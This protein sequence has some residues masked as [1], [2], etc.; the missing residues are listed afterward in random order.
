MYTASTRQQQYFFT[1]NTKKC[2]TYS[3]ARYVLP[4]YL[5]VCL[6]KKTFYLGHNF[7]TLRE[8]DLIFGMHTHLIKPNQMTSRSMILWHWP[9]PLT[10]I[11][12]TITFT[13]TLETSRVRAFVLNMCISCDKAFLLIL[14][15]LTFSPSHI[16]QITDVLYFLHEYCEKKSEAFTEF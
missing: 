1:Q 2:T 5:P 12:K 8:R 14:K 6:W 3:Y 7:G 10:Y 9:W 11:K 13:I 16:V 15:F 4:V